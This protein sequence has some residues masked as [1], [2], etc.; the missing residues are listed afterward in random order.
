MGLILRSVERRPQIQFPRDRKFQNILT[1][2]LPNLTDCVIFRANE[3]KMA[4]NALSQMLLKLIID[5]VYW[6]S[7][8][9]YATQRTRLRAIWTTLE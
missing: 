9:F 5:R 6:F 2:F 4:E 7:L 1:S 8:P 3:H